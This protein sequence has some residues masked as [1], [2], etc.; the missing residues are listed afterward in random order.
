[1]IPHLVLQIHVIHRLMRRVVVAI[2]VRDFH[3]DIAL[4]IAQLDFFKI[5]Q[6]ERDEDV[7]FEFGEPHAKT[8]MPP[9]AP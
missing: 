9:G 6:E 7:V 3:G 4:G 5:R 1:M 2:G 8:W